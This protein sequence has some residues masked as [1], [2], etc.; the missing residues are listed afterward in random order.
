MDMP[1]QDRQSLFPKTLS[2]A[3]GRQSAIVTRKNIRIA[4]KWGRSRSLTWNHSA[5]PE[6]G[7]RH[8][9]LA[10]QTQDRQATRT[11]HHCLP[12]SDGRLADRARSHLGGFAAALKRQKGYKDE[13]A[14]I[15]TL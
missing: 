10:A 5:W 2:R 15:V 6:R 7:D 9:A 11:V 4:R 13:T 12:A 3:V 8:W 1:A 14:A